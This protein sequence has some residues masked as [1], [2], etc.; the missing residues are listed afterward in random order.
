MKA[1]NRAFTEASTVYMTN[2]ISPEALKEMYQMP[3]IADVDIMDRDGYL[4]I[5][6]EGGINLKENW[7]GQNL[8]DYDYVV[9]LTHF[10]GHP[11]NEK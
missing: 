9:V 6:V 1:E 5:P 10:K 11:Y 3:E 8:A 7:V 2:E 4:K